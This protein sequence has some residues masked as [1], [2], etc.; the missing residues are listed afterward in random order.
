MKQMIVDKLAVDPSL[1]ADTETSLVK[2]Q[3]LQA[4]K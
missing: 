4:V 2:I 1:L 3:K